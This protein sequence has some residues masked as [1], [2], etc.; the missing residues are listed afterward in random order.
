MRCSAYLSLPEKNNKINIENNIV[1][2]ITNWVT[3]V[4]GIEITGKNNKFFSFSSGS[5]AILIAELEYK[6]LSW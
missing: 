1:L 6:L 3:L 2:V 5:M 4:P